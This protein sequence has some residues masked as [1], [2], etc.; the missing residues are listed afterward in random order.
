MDAGRELDALVAEKVMGYRLPEDPD[1]AR[2]WLCWS[3]ADLRYVFSG[4]WAQ[5]PEMDEDDYGNP[6]VSIIYAIAGSDVWRPSIDIAAAWQVVE[7]MIERGAVGFRLQL[8]YSGAGGALQ[9]EAWFYKHGTNIPKPD[10]F[11]GAAATNGT[12]LSICLAAL[13]AVTPPTA[14]HPQP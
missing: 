1:I 7:K 12:P 14:E 8:I 11:T 9:H 2:A 5:E 3:E 6:T 13:A 4:W 10:W